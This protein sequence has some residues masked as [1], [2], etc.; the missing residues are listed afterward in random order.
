M[1]TK[2]GLGARQIQTTKLSPLQ[3]TTIKLIEMPTLDLLR[4]IDDE[5]M[6][7]PAL[8]EDE[9]KERDED[10][11][12]VSLDTIKDDDPIPSYNLKLQRSSDSTDDRTPFATL[13]ER[14]NFYKSL[15][16]QLGSEIFL[17]SSMQSA[18]LSL[19]ASMAMDIFDV[20][21]RQ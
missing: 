12:E 5:I 13:S 16:E 4:R 11:Q 2:L 21:Y 20:I 8:E 15:K 18:P 19:A 7:N 9:S 17:S 14:E 1:S 3:I 6:E 10:P